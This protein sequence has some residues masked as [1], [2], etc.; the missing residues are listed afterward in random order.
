M[1]AEYA[2]EHRASSERRFIR[3]RMPRTLDGFIGWL[4]TRANLEAPEAIHAATIWRDRVSLSELQAGI[5]AV[6][7]SHL[8]SPAYSGLF[9]LIVEGNVSAVDEDGFYVTPLRSALSRLARRQ[10]FMARA[11]AGLIG[12]GGD[13]RKLAQYND[14]HPE[15]AEVYLHE[16]LRRLWTETY[17]QV[18]RR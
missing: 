16:G 7:G 2:V 3:S 18:V 17:D 1:Q 4:L 6:G 5:H 15:M 10:P 11:I 14:W 12:C 13:W 9:R 8:G